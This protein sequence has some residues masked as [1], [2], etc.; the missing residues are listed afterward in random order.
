MQQR[1]DWMVYVALRLRDTFLLIGVRSLLNTRSFVE[2]VSI[3]RDSPYSPSTL[4]YD[5]ALKRRVVI[6]TI[7][8]IIDVIMCIDT[9]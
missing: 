4:D 5:I 6:R 3:R 7:M 9:Y 1:R 8:S 2:C